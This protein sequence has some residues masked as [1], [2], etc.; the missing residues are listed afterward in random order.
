VA[1]W[2]IAVASASLPTDPASGGIQ[3]R[4]VTDR[5]T[6]LLGLTAPARLRIWAAAKSSRFTSAISP[7]GAPTE[8]AKDI[9]YC[10]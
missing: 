10:E 3:R 4:A 5:S 2:L 9:R 7:L 8:E 1:T 6:V